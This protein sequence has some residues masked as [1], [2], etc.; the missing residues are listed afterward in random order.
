LTDYRA[1]PEDYGAEQRRI[2]TYA[3]Q[4]RV[5]HVAAKEYEFIGASQI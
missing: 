2:S 3:D 4:F 1:S 5:E